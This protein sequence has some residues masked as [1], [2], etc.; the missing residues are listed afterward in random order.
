V[1]S[2]RGVEGGKRFRKLSRLVMRVLGSR[3]LL[4]VESEGRWFLVASGDASVEGRLRP[5]TEVLYVLCGV[6]A[7]AASARVSV[8]MPFTEVP[9]TLQTF[10]LILIILLLGRNAWRVVSTYIALG[11]AGLP[12]FAY[13]GGLGYL[14]SP[15]MGYLV[16]FF[17]SSLLGYL[18]RSLSMVRFILISLLAI[19]ITYT[20]GWS[21]LTLWYSI[22]QGLN[23][24][25]RSLALLAFT[26]GV[27]PFI[28]WDLLKGIAASVVAY[29][30]IRGGRKLVAIKSLIKLL[31]NVS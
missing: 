25:M 12:V 22:T 15:T 9:F 17:T 6:F 16:G 20:F 27:A 26:R 10:T 8:V 28:L 24:G 29:E 5:L 23:V 30:V 13:G 19:L 3:E 11:L 21:W 31:R 4:Y 1:S 2:D 14:V 7:L 18:R